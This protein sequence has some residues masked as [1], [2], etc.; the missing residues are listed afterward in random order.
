MVAGGQS[1]CL[2]ISQM[3]CPPSASI[4]STYVVGLQIAED[5]T[6]H[7]RAFTGRALASRDRVRTVAAMST[8][9][10]LAPLPAMVEC[11]DRQCHLLAS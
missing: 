1:G 9:V 11:G 7:G 2:A 5:P 10:D 4:T 3:T 8:S 6:D